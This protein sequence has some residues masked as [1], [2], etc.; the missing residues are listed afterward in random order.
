MNIKDDEIIKMIEDEYSKVFN[1]ENEDEIIKKSIKSFTNDLPFKI[2]LQENNSD[3]TITIL[4]KDNFYNISKELS[5]LLDIKSLD[6]TFSEKLNL[7][8]NYEIYVDFNTKS[9][10]INN[11]EMKLNSCLCYKTDFKNIKI[12][13]NKSKSKSK[14]ND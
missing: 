6:E 10:Y 1:E 4:D 13:K 7:L 12:K 3:K 9:K 5:N 11:K 2:Y 14:S 8:Q